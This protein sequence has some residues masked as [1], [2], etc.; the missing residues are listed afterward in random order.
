MRPAVRGAWPGLLIVGL[1]ASIA[2]LDFAVN[3]AF[4][5][6]VQAFDLPTR[7]IRWAAICYVITYGSLM[8]GFGALGDRIG[9]LRVFRAGLILGAVA[10]SLCALAPGYGWLLAARMVQGVAVALT[11]SCAPAL[12]TLLVDERERTWALSA[13]AG[14]AAVASVVAP[15]AGG[16]SV[17]LMGW[18]G[19]FAF[20]VPIAL[21]ALGCLPLLASAA[22]RQA[23]RG[24]APAFDTAG[25]VLLAVAVA[26]LLLGPSL[27][28]PDSGAG[29]AVAVTL[30]GAVLMALFVRRQHGAP[31][32]F[33]PGA[34]VRDPDFRRINLAACT[35][36]LTSFAVPLIVPFYLLRDGG[37][38]PIGTGALLA[39]WALGTLA[40]SGAAARVVVALGAWR[41]ALAGGTL[42]AAGLAGV[43][44]WPATPQAGAMIACLLLQ[45]AGSGLFQVAYTDAV[46]AAL[47]AAARGVAGSLAMV[48]RT[49]G[50]VLGATAWMW[51]LQSS[52]EAARA[53]GS[54]PR[55]ALM[56]GFDAVFRTA[57]AV[58]AVV[59]VFVAAAYARSDRPR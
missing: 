34:L 14:T 36:N 29:P 57:T 15:L 12:A 47:P 48:T 20:R 5:S 6:I 46:V 52:E 35:V 27:L 8:L 30:A 45:G 19:V 11:L 53:A 37:W 38:T 59:L 44:L 7:S 56:A 10:F 51:L 4:P 26:L 54:T 55:E 24:D 28:G 31:A 1:G 9:Y 2:P 16:L 23:P 25:S 42:A 33:I 17:M 18:Q 13:Y 43:A 32:P 49:V 58:A 39:A 41:A 40:G 50:V 21:A 22:L 3:I